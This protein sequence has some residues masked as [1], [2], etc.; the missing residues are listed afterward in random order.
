MK[1]VPVTSSW[2]LKGREVSI[3]SKIKWIIT[4]KRFHTLDG[5]S[6][7]FHRVVVYLMIYCNIMT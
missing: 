7:K 2:K 3:F 6:L 1:M 5:L 4:V